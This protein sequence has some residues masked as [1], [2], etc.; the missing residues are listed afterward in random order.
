MWNCSLHFTERK[1][2][3]R[4]RGGNSERLSSLARV[5]RFL[6]HSQSPIFGVIV[7]YMKNLFLRLLGWTWSCSQIHELQANQD[8]P[9]VDQSEA[10]LEEEKLDMIGGLAEWR[11]HVVSTRVP[12]VLLVHQIVQAHAHLA[13]RRVCVVNSSENDQQMVVCLN[14]DVWSTWKRER[15]VPQDHFH[16]SPSWFECAQKIK[17][18]LQAHRRPCER[19]SLVKLG[20]SLPAQPSCKKWTNSEYPRICFRV[21]PGTWRMKRRRIWTEAGGPQRV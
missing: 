12:H 17:A 3:R 2:K 14:E 20:G 6:A 11:V 4:E 9:H 10:W 5:W 8:M 19:D 21:A 13:S 1:S 15:N 7:I 18:S 16:W